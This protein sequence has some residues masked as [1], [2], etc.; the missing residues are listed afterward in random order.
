MFIYI[1]LPSACGQNF[2]RKFYQTFTIA[3]IMRILISFKFTFNKR[4]K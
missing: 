1:I 3:V 4:V 2:E